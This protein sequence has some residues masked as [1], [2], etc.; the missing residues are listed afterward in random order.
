MKN[1]IRFDLS[2]YL[3]H[4]FRDVDQ[5]SKNYILFPEHAGF[6]NLNQSTKLDA[7]FLMRCA[8]RHQKLCA[9]WSYRNL[10]RAIYG[11]EPAVCFTDMPLAAFMKTSKERM[12][13]GE[14]IGE[15]ALILPK[16]VMFSSGARPVIYAL[17][18]NEIQFLPSENNEERIISPE[19]LPLNEQYRYVTY[20]PSSARPI[21]WT[22]EREWRWSY[23]EDLSSFNKELARD[24]VYEDLESYPGLIFSDLGVIGAGVLV[25]DESDV[26][27]VLFDILTLVDR[28]L[29]DQK[30][31]KFIL[32]TS[33]LTSHLDIIDPKELSDFINKSIVDLSSYFYVDK[34]YDKNI[35]NE[36]DDII[37]EEIE[38]ADLS[39]EDFGS[40]Y[41]K[42]W[43]WVVENQPKFTR[44]LMRIGKISVNKE[45]RYLIGLD[46][47]NMFSLKKQEYICKNI[48]TRLSEK[49]SQRCSYFSVGGDDYDAVPFYTDFTDEQHEFYNS[50]V[51]VD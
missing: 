18:S 26:R 13:R 4:F 41:G 33:K 22:H 38:K 11:K 35:C 21:D 37:N 25:H 44:T 17:S 16:S 3:I 28:G 1:N 50:T 51:N 46:G 39:T 47:M 40:E 29:I 6:T 42:S 43:V 27:K 5:E 45:G 32:Q 2:E 19:L 10:V 24:G 31:F 36:V 12:G 49:Y 9:T 30:A 14:N 23:K 15:Y 34:N 8:L 48:A 20:D 7:L